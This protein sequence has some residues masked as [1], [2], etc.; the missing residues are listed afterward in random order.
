M[1]T[2]SYWYID[3]KILKVGFP[4]IL[5]SA[6]LA[7]LCALGEQQLRL[8]VENRHPSFKSSIYITDT[9]NDVGSTPLH[10]YCARATG[11]V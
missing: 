6:R 2:F 10:E 5:A 3:F 11:H 7:R 4:I 9:V 1:L 8:K